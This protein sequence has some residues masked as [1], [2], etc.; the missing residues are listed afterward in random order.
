MHDRVTG[1]LPWQLRI[2]NRN[3]FEGAATGTFPQGRRRLA[4]A[5][6][7][8]A[9]YAGGAAGAEPDAQEHDRIDYTLSETLSYDNNLFRLSPG[10]D[11]RAVVGE[12]ARREDYIDKTSLGLKAHWLAARQSFDVGAH[13]DDNRFR[14]N[15]DLNHVAGNG[16]AIW[17][18]ALGDDW[19]GR[20]GA[21]YDRSLAAFANNQFLGKDMLSSVDYFVE[22]RDQLTPRWSLTGGAHWSKADHSAADRETENL[23]SKTGSVGLRYETPRLNAYGLSYRYT[24][25]HFPD[26]TVFDRDYSETAPK[27]W[28]KYRFTAKTDLDARFGYLRRDYPNGE[29]GDFSGEFWRATLNWAPTAKTQVEFSGWHELQAYIEAGSDYFVSEG[30]GIA[31]A[32]QPNP[33]WKVMLQYSFDNQRFIGSTPAPFGE[34]RRRDKVRSRSMAVTYA[35]LRWLDLG[36]S[37]RFD[38]RTSNR[39]MLDYDDSTVSLGATVKF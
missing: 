5:I 25:A 16:Q 36:L 23:S 39:D 38:R 11:A 17:N 32:W 18:W 12:N 35:P 1:A 26:S 15:D 19:S 37:Y 10:I 3:S 28:L 13:V 6:A 2:Q 33:H 34:P 27:A 20:A 29:I 14:Y 9:L 4:L 24:D 31:P 21:I 8:G 30:I 22:G 7:L